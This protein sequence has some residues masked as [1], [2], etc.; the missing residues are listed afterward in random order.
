MRQDEEN[1]QKKIMDDKSRG[2]GIL[3][4]NSQQKELME[5]QLIQQKYHDDILLKYAL[6]KE[7]SQ[8]EAEE[9]KKRMNRNAGQQ[10]K[11]YLEEQMQ[12][13]AENQSYLDDIRHKEEERVWKQRDEVLAA[14]DVARRE[15]MTEVYQSRE[16]QIRAKAAQLL[17]EKY[18]DSQ[19]SK[20][21]I[22][23]AKIAVENDG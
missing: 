13:E 1:I 10:Y 4:F 12:K 19:F 2:K 7:K 16:E 8:I 21:F 3:E 15:L 17:R 20:Q 6:Q 5:Q 22:Q 14:R 9:K 23:S 11:R 18:E